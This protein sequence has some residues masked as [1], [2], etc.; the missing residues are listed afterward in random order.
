M[1]ATLKGRSALV[2]GGLSGMGLEIARALASAGAGVSVGSYVAAAATRPDDAAY[3]PAS[4]E[5]AA[6]RADLAGRGVKVF[7]GH[8][9]VRNSEAVRRF[10]KRLKRR[11][12]PSTS[13]SMPPA[14]PPNSPSAV[15]RTNC[16]RKSSK[17][18]FPA[19]ST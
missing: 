10:V 15:I 18:I 17:P 3:Y 2:T 6:V 13:S 1:S 8:L 16:G 19:P 7:A 4:G 12:V 14:P 5:I 9:D 11:P